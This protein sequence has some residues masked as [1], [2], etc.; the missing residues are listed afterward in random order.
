MKNL[1]DW[2]NLLRRTPI[3]PQWL[4]GRRAPPL[5]ISDTT[6]VVLDIGAADRWVAP[7]LSQ[8]ATYVALD[9]PPTEKE[10][11]HAQPDVFADACK[12]PIG[13]NSVDGIV[14]LEVLEHVEN[15]A[16][17]V[18]EMA[19]VLKIG[20]RAWISMPFMYPLHNEPFDFQRYTEFGLR[21]DMK[22]AHL[23]VVSLTRPV[24]AIRTAG[25]LACLAIAGGIHGQKLLAKAVLLPPGTLAIFFINVTSWLVSFFWP[26]WQNLTMRHELCVRKNS[27]T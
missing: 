12:L 27:C 26:D 20:G 19:R 15:P 6:G 21:R 1:R 2:A 3:H 23:E 5:G 24:H 4:L 11:Y 17:A 9:Y 16:G 14:C 13:S 25:L 22:L 10:F 7:Y 18:M 8:Q